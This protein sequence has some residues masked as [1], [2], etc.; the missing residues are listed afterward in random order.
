LRAGE[1][2]HRILK[3]YPHSGVTGEQVVNQIV[4]EAAAAGVAVE[5]RAPY[6]AAA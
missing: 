1:H 4:M 6:P 5:I 3:A 2:A